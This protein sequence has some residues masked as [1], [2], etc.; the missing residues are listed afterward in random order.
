MKKIF[1][2]KKIPLEGLL[3][4]LTNLYEEGTNFI[5]ISGEVGT[6]TKDI[7]HIDVLPEYMS[8]P[9]EEFVM[10]QEDDINESVQVTKLSDDDINNLI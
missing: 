9:E 8:D 1:T 5:D 4:I 2:V 6:V 10:E 7:L 3:E